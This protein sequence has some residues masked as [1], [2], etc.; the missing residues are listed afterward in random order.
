[1]DEFPLAALLADGVV[2]V[3]RFGSVR[4]VNPAAEELLGVSRDDLL[5]RIPD[6]PIIPGE[7]NEIEVTR[8]DGSIVVEVRVAEIVWDGEPGAAASLRDVTERARSSEQQQLVIERLREL[9]QLKTEFVSLV[10][11]DLRTPM[12]TISGFADTLRT[13]WDALDEDAKKRML[14][15]ISEKADQLSHLVENVLQVGQ[16]ETGKLSYDLRAVDVRDVIR[17]VVRESADAPQEGIGGRVSVQVPDDLP[18]VLADE[19]R[20][21]QILTNLVGNALKY[22]P[23][24]SAVEVRATV[25]Q[26]HVVVSVR[27]EGPGIDEKDRDKLFQKFTRLKQD[28]EMRTKGTGLGL[29]ISKAMIEAQGGRIWVDSAPDQGST[30]SYS[31]PRAISRIAEAGAG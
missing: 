1:M 20:Q 16:I 28:S 4:F 8:S 12:A 3:D 26:G 22:S 27:D 5:G 15:R 18:L 30:F 2:V 10:S 11:H 14:E 19:L 23:S 17:R 29:Y 7:E 31:I 24:G 9:D 13:N 21:W 6:F 25:E